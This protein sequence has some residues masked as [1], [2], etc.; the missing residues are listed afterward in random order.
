MT[1]NIKLLALSLLAMGS[2]FTACN[3]DDDSI[4]YTKYYEWRD[5]NNLYADLCLQDIKQMGP[6]AYF[7]DSVRSQK[8]PWA[9]RHTLY[10]VLRAANEDSLRAINK[11]YSPLYNS[12]LKAHYTLYD[13]K[14]VMERFDD[15]LVLS[16][17]E[18]RN[19][20]E[21]MNKIFG[22]GYRYG[23]PG[24]EL[25]AD[26][27]ES[28]QVEFLEDFTPGSVITG[29]GDVLQNMHIG[30]SWL[31]FIPWFL[32]YGQQGSG[33]NIDPYTNLFFRIELCDITN[34]GA[35]LPKEEQ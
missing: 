10:R 35:T 28:K 27:L 14:S 3:K 15:N 22:I 2:V 34:W 21:L 26:T 20:A 24:Y 5:K 23:M 31:V 17:K 18:S 13:T 33:S 4:D 6:M 32:G 7:T 8:E 30:D 19:N 16:S 25:K 12:K 1:K 11:W 29:W 9:L